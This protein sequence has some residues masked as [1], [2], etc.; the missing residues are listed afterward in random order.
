MLKK[1]LIRTASLD[2]IKPSQN[3]RQQV[4]DCTRRSAAAY[5]PV[6]AGLCMVICR[7]GLPADA[8]NGVAATTEAAPP[9]NAGTELSLVRWSGSLPEEA[10]RMVQMR[11]APYQDQADGLALWSETQT[12]KVGLDGHYSMLLGATSIEGLPHQPLSGA[13]PHR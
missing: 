4:F 5:L 3:R 8:Q 12:V 7:L 6:A 9:V 2:L 13:I 1:N 11:F 10:G